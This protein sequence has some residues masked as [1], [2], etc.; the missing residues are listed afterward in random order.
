MRALV[1]WLRSILAWILPVYTL[2]LPALAFAHTVR[3]RVV[4][5]DVGEPIA[6]LQVRLL[7]TS[8]IAYTDEA[9]Q[10]VLAGADEAAVT[11]EIRG[12]VIVPLRVQLNPHDVPADWTLVVEFDVPDEQIVWVAA[13]DTRTASASSAHLVARD[14]ASTPLRTADDI[15][16]LVP[17]V[18]LVQHGT[19][20]KGPQFFLRGFD[21]EHGFDLEVKVDGI[22][23]NEWSNVHAQ[24]YL[25]LAFL[26]PEVVHAVDVTKGPFG[27]EPGPFALAGSVDYHL[28]VAPDQVGW[29][30]SYTAGTTG[31]H[32][33][34]GGWSPAG[35]AT[36][37]TV[38]DSEQGE[39]FVALEALVDQGFG[40]RRRTMRASGLGRWAG[41]DA[42]QGLRVTAAAYA[43]TFE[44][45]GT[46]RADDVAAGGVGFYDAYD[47]GNHG[48]S[49]RGLVGVSYEFAP[50]QGGRQTS[51]L[52]AWLGWRR[53]EL[54]ENYT[55]WL[56]HPERGDRRQ[57]R[58]STLTF[59]ADSVTRV[60]LLDTW[61]GT[62]GVGLRGDSLTQSVRGV[63]TAGEVYETRRDADVLQLSPNLRLGLRWT[64]S[65]DVKIE[66]GSRVDAFYV[67]ISDALAAG[68]T[69]DRWDLVVSPRVAVEVWLHESVR[70]FATYGRGV[71]PT[72]ARALTGQAPEALGT[73]VES[74][75]AAAGDTTASDNV[76]TGLRWQPTLEWSTTL[77]A[78]ATFIERESL[79]D[80]V[81][82]LA[83][84][85]NGTRRLGVEFELNYRPTSWLRFRGDLTWVDARFTESG[86]DV[87]FVPTLMGGL[88]A[89]LELSCGW[90]A[91]AHFFG[92]APRTLPHGATGSTL[93]WLDL[94]V[95]YRWRWLDASIAVENALARRL[96]PGELHYASDWDRTQPASRIPVLHTAAGPPT[97]ARFTLGARW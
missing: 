86:R 46:V 15:L 5:A 50:T 79:F 96:Q 8:A 21:A 33:V 20:G 51:E 6:G 12:D 52:H 9:G 31:R 94:G 32:R 25:D 10:F 2:L 14:F 73:V 64:P 24:G 37:D 43:A 7:G 48:L 38:A 40:Q 72:E 18:A 54:L 4:D 11:V 65:R 56:V 97:N 74:A 81:S 93:L 1:T 23:L 75:S 17:G 60:P 80:H 90:H 42:L 45:P 26:I 13:P 77:S 71:R 29:R 67:W 27:L 19:E 82:G 89:W 59:G 57:Q 85:L 92:I 83:L 53:L 63:D 69:A 36:S 78:F 61:S 87:P 62:L 28:G 22:P 16:R 68:A 39:S 55:G 95:G 70:W 44:L 41:E 66:A 88:H 58:Q 84:E 35:A 47:Q 91:A 49:A 76:E 34:F 30:A 3:G